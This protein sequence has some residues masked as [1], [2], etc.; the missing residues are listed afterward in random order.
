MSEESDSGRYFRDHWRA[1]VMELAEGAARVAQAQA[2]ELVRIDERLKSVERWGR[3]FLGVAGTVVAAG[4]V[5]L[6]SWFFERP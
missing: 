5:A 2:Q 6:L 4:I 3:W 1:K